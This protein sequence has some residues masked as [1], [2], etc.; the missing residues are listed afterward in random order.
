MVA[1]MLRLIVIHQIETEAE[2]AAL[3]IRE[4]RKMKTECSSGKANRVNIPAVI[5]LVWL[6][7]HL[8]VSRRRRGTLRISARK[9]EKRR[10]AAC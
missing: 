9:T 1:R 4:K 8:I 2:F 6:S 7:P 10:K 5:R 3:R